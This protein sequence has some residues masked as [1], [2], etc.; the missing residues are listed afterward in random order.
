MGV[1]VAAGE[2]VGKDAK[3]TKGQTGV[4]QGIDHAAQDGLPTDGAVETQGDAV[5]TTP[6]ES[7]PGGRQIEVTRPTLE[8]GTPGE[9]GGEDGRGVRVK[10]TGELS[11]LT[12]P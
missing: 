10:A 9:I 4:G 5:A 6:R 3:D 2:V 1:T 7:Q 11:G 8:T 12:G